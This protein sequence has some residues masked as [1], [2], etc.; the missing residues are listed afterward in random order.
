MQKH[1]EICQN[2]GYTLRPEVSNPLGSMVSTMFCW[3]KNTPKPDF[4]EKRKQIIQNTKTQNRLEIWQNKQ[5]TLRP[6][7]S[8]PSGSKNVQIRDH[9]FPL[10]FSKDSESLKSLDIRLREVGAKRLLN[11]TSKVKRQTDRQTDRRTDTQTDRK[12][13]ILTNR[14]HRPRG[15]ML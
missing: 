15:L 13:D 12:T 8:N 4:F 2:Q 9:F 7:V 14:K 11:D 10:L 1:L 5:Y 3:T 6:E